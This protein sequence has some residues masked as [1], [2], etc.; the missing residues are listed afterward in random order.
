MQNV[1]FSLSEIYSFQQE[2]YWNIPRHLWYMYWKILLLT[3]D[4]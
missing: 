4:H 1:L 2:T 3:L